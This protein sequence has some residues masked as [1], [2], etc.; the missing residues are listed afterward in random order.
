MIA[1]HEHFVSRTNI[2]ARL[3]ISEHI[4]ISIVCGA[5][6]PIQSYCHHVFLQ[7]MFE[8][9][10]VGFIPTLLRHANL[11]EIGLG[12]F[13]SKVRL[14]LLLK[15]FMLGVTPPNKNLLQDCHD[16]PVVERLSR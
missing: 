5:C 15:V 12:Y 16:V 14:E 13:V 4:G 8:Q 11:P 7:E 6:L 10:I 1:K 3:R 9:F 2:G